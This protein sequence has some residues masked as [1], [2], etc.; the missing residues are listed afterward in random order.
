MTL[1]ELYEHFRLRI[2][3]LKTKR[4]DANVA[5]QLAINQ[6]IFDGLFSQL[7]TNMRTMM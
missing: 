5:A 7:E 3:D 4:E 2:A 6:A 1:L